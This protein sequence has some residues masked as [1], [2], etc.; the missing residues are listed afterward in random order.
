MK[1]EERVNCIS[2]VFF[3]SFSFEKASF[4]LKVENFV[5]FLEGEK[6]VSKNLVRT[7]IIW[8]ELSCNEIQCTRKKVFESYKLVAHGNKNGGEIVGLEVALLFL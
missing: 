5:I 2:S 1:L 6:K 3:R 7:K 4:S 8:L